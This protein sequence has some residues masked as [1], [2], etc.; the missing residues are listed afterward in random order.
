MTQLIRDVHFIDET[1]LAQTDSVKP[2]KKLIID[3]KK[4]C[5][6]SIGSEIFTEILAGRMFTSEFMD[7]ALK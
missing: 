1:C 4:N 7:V 2:G 6:I 3:H 5:C